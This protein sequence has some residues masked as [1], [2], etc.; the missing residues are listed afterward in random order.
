M[1]GMVMAR[2]VEVRE[3]E[4]TEMEAEAREEAVTEAEMGGSPHS[5]APQ[6]PRS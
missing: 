2:Q 4:V 6:T 5:H 1:G 3:A